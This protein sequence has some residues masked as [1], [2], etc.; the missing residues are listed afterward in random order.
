MK[1]EFAISAVVPK[2]Y[3]CFS[4]MPLETDQAFSAHEKLVVFQKSPPMS[5]YV[6]VSRTLR[7]ICTSLTHT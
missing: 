6:S 4:N 1:A 7:S 2:T 5:T 3:Q